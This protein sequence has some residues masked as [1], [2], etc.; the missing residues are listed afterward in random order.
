MVKL[1][2]DNFGKR[3]FGGLM[4]FTVILM[5]IVPADMRVLSY[6]TLYF[7]VEL[8]LIC[9]GLMYLSEDIA[10]LIARNKQMQKWYISY[11]AKQWR[12]EK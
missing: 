2:Y 11:K 5:I 1:N 12:D 4:F 6:N 7:L 10:R 9:L 8:L 3:Y